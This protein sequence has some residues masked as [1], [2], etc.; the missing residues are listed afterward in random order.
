MFALFC[1]DFGVYI[2]KIAIEMKNNSKNKPNKPLQYTE[3]E[4]HTTSSSTVGFGISSGV[5]VCQH[6][7]LTS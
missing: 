1:F 5:A 7:Y 6:E 4:K 2:D 3:K